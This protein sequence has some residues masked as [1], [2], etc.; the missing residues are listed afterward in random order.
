MGLGNGG[1]NANSGNRGSNWRYEYNVLKALECIVDNTTSGGG[2]GCCPATNALLA[3]IAANT[4]DIEVSLGAGDITVELAGVE[5]RLDTVIANQT[6]GTQVVTGPLT[7][8]QLRATPVPVSFTPS[9]TQNENL[10]EVNTN[11]V[12]TGIG[13][14]GSGTQRV[15]VSSNSS[16]ALVTTLGTITNPLPSGTNIL[17]SVG[18]DQTTPGTTNGVVINS[19][20]LPTGASTSANQTIANTSLSAI[21]ISLSSVS[22]TPSLLVTS[23]PG[24]IPAG[25]RSVSVFNSGL[26]SGVWLGATIP[27]GVQLSYDAGGQSDTLTAFTYDG[28]GT[29]LIITTVV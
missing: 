7:N 22:R 9:G 13:V 17:G 8:V 2:A 21:S 18:I 11:P 6:N 23:A 4:A 25:T 15:A 16:L 3:T 20:V 10:T 28:T 5:S 27:T 24:T 1:M 29:T 14:A 19:S 26:A 12:D